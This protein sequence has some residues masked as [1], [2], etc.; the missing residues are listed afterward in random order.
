MEK[1][2]LGQLNGFGDG[3]PSANSR[4]RFGTQK[5]EPLIC[6][7]ECPGGMEDSNC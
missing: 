6:G 7:M 3:R 2:Y 1:L 5:S 4:S